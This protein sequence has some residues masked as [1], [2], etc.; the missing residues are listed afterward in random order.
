MC[1]CAGM[2]VCHGLL[3]LCCCLLRCWA[4]RLSHEHS[5]GGPRWHFWAAA[6]IHPE[7]RLG[8]AMEPVGST[9]SPAVARN[10][11]KRQATIVEMLGGSPDGVRSQPT[12]ASAKRVADSARQIEG[13]D[14]STDDDTASEDGSDT[15]APP[16]RSKVH[17]AEFLEAQRLAVTLKS[18]KR[19]VNRYAAGSSRV[20]A[21]YGSLPGPCAGTIVSVSMTNFMCHRKFHM[22][23]VRD[24]CMP[25]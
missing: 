7:I 13:F 15:E 23:F 12:R 21:G 25:C 14:D 9:D 16:K 24:P 6:F 20:G 11:T 22:D 8:H 2:P 19:L 18:A 17:S 3:F 10:A 4:R 1:R 5:L